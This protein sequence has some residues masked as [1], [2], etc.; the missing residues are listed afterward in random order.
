MGVSQVVLHQAS[1]GHQGLKCNVGASTT[2]IKLEDCP[3]GND[4]ACATTKATASGVTVSTYTCAPAKTHD[5]C[6][7]QTVAV[8]SS[9]L[10][11]CDTDGCNKS[12]G[13]VGIGMTALVWISTIVVA[14]NLLS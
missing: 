4:K 7:A 14:V 13:A 10:C 12:S 11:F 3:A 1:V 2:T 8:G 6:K 5:G 9:D